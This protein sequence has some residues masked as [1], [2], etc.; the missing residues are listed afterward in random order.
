MKYT[1]I[2]LF[3]SGMLVAGLTA[4]STTTINTTSNEELFP[5]KVPGNICYLKTTRKSHLL[6][7]KSSYN[8]TGTIIDQN[9]IVT[10][11]HN[12][13]DSFW[14][15][16]VEVSVT[17]KSSNGAIVTTVIPLEVIEE[18]RKVSHYDEKF[19]QDYAFLYFEEPAQVGNSISLNTSTPIDSIEGIKVAGYPGGKLTYGEGMVTK[20]IPGDSTFYYDVDTAKGMSGGPVWAS[21]DGKD[22][23]VG[24]HVS[25]GRARVI[26]EA[27]VEDFENW[28]QS[29][30]KP[31]N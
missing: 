29:I 10:A 17:Y 11:A 20:P 24:V 4:C 13:Y 3:T 14:T 8:A 25:E 6:G 18:T 26:D 7:S 12:V 1:S 31:T 21:V 5:E 30:N 23:L 16:L 9:H 22:I 2:K 15:D 28:K 27:L 19:P